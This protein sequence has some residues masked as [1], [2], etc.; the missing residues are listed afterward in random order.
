[1][2]IRGFELRAQDVGKHDLL[3]RRLLGAALEHAEA[4]TPPGPA[5][6]VEHVPAVERQELVLAQAG[7]QGHGE[8]D[9]VTEAGAVLAGHLQQR[10]LLDLG[11]R[12]RRTR[13]GGSIGELPWPERTW[14][15]EIGTSAN[16]QPWRCGTG[17]AP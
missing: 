1:M 9:V 8:D 7:P 3:D 10:G 17:P 2:R 11:E 13:D 4:H 15:R 12:S 14:L 6:V 16:N 5:V